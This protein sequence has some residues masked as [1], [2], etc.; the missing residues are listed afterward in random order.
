MVLTAAERTQ[1]QK[2]LNLSVCCQLLHHIET[3][4][5]WS[6]CVILMLLFN[7]CYKIQTDGNVKIGNSKSAVKDPKYERLEAHTCGIFNNLSY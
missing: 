5:T 1:Q 7:K 6:V 2:V 4:S 3:N